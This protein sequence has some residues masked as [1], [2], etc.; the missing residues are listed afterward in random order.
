MEKFEV[1]ILGCGCAAPTARHNPAAQIVNI[2]EKLS[3]IDCGE[4]TQVEMRKN[5]IGFMKIRNVFISHLHGDHCFGLIGLISSMGLLGR[6]SALH[7]Y[8]PANFGELLQKQLDIF[9]EGMEYKVEFHPLDTQ[10]YQSIYED[11]SVEVFTIPLKHRIPCCGFLFKEKATLPHI[12]REKIDYYKI[13]LSE[14]NNIKNGADWITEDG[15]V[16]PNNRLTTPAATTRSYAYC[17]DTAFKPDIQ[18]YLKGVDLLYHE[19]TFGSDRIERARI[20]FHSTAEEA[21][22]MA[23]ESQVKQLLIG[24]YSAHYTDESILLNE[25]KKIFPNTLAAQEGM[26]IKL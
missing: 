1:T 25:A 16:I 8:A 11:R 5:R 9:C 2:R 24:H 18:E 26:T 15:T 17:S 3:L 6:T 20:T 19:A 21:A 7:I 12:I 22:I 10:K 13:P 23:R 4:G 14:I